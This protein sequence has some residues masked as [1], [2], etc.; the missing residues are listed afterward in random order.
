M[1]QKGRRCPSNWYILNGEQATVI[2]LT[3][4]KMLKKF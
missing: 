3:P 2:L 1:Q 4:S